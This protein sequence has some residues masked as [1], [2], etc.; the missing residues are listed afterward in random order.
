MAPRPM[1]KE[2]VRVGAVV[3]LDTNTYKV[4]RRDFEPEA[5]SPDLVERLGDVGHNFFSTAANNIE[6]RGQGKGYFDRMVYTAKGIS[7]GSLEKFDEFIKVR[8]QEYIEEI[9]NWFA[10]EEKEGRNERN[11]RYT[12]FYMVHYV[13]EADD[14]SSLS[15]L[16]KDRGL[17]K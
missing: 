5:L 1:L 6:K 15:K 17:K 8:G 7:E 10:A 4:V 14:K 2:L 3:E 16:L 9:D 13:E 12:G 11:K